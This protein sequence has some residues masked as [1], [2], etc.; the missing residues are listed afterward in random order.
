MNTS[1]EK[2]EEKPK[3]QKPVYISN[4]TSQISLNEFMGLLT[5]N[6]MVY[7]NKRGKQHTFDNMGVAS[8]KSVKVEDRTGI[9]Y[10]Y[11]VVMKT[12]LHLMGD[13]VVF[14]WDNGEVKYTTKLNHPDLNN[15][16]GR[17]YFDSVK[18]VVG[19][20]K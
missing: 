18:S 20:T 4:P 7:Y 13:V 8:K 14:E 15:W 17:L 12:Y 19:D 6:P 9:R 3:K 16:S 2:N 1:N 5:T 11:I 10:K